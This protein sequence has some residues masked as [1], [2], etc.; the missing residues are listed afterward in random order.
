MSEIETRTLEIF[1]TFGDLELRAEGGNKLVGY[2]AVFGV[3]SADLGG[4]RERILPG[5]FKASLSSGQ[6]IRALVDHD[7]SKLLGRTSANT[8]RLAEDTRG[9]RAEIDLPDT[10]AA[11]DALALVKRGDVRGM[12]FGF[13]VAAGGDRF[14]TEGNQMIRELTAVDL[15]EV[16]VTSIPAYGATSLAVRVDPSLAARIKEHQTQPVLVKRAMQY[17]QHLAK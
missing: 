8:L 9:L 6:D 16:T 3:L 13:R 11:R 12:S 15:R 17:R 14:T 5:A 7:P 4:F 1:G 2:A 10:Q